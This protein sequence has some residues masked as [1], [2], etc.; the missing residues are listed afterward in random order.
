MSGGSSKNLGYE[1]LACLLDTDAVLV[2]GGAGTGKTLLAW[3]LALVRLRRSGFDEEERR[4]PEFWERVTRRAAG[5]KRLR[6]DCVFD[7]VVVDEGQDFGR[8]EWKI[9]IQALADGYAGKTC[10]YGAVADG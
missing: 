6:W 3:D 9:G 2:R 5:S 8:Y 7:T 10:D 4:E 1:S